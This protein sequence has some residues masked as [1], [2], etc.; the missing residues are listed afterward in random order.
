MRRRADSRRAESSKGFAFSRGQHV[1]HIIQAAHKAAPQRNTFGPEGPLGP[2]RR[3][4]EIFKTLAHRIVDHGL[5]AG[6]ADFLCPLQQRG[7]IVVQAE[8]RSHASQRKSHDVNKK[9]ECGDAGG[10]QN[11]WGMA[12]RPSWG[13]WR[14][15]D[16]SLR[17]RGACGVVVSIMEDRRPLIA[18]GDGNV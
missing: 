13:V 5:E 15:R 17:I 2:C 4:Q 1:G 14:I 6:F 16:F 11:Y 3:P 7:H 10:R 18:E 8:H 9:E 12:P